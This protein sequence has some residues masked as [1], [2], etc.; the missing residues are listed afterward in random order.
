MQEAF[1]GVSRLT[2]EPTGHDGACCDQ[3]A[4]TTTPD[5]HHPLLQA[6]L[7]DAGMAQRRAVAKAI[8]LLESTQ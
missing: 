7:G 1:P 2:L 3:P 6:L 8:T 5:I 4:M